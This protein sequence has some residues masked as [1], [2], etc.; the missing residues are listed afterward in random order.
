[1]IPRYTL[2]EMGAIWSERGALRGHAAGRARGRPRAGR[3]RPDP[4]RGAGRRSRRARASTS[5]GSPR[6]SGPRTTTSSRSS[7]RSPRSVG[8]GGPL[9]PPRADQQRRRRHRRSRS[10]S[11]PPASGCSST[12]DRLLAAIVAR[13]RAEADDRDDGPHPLGPRRADDVRAQARRLGVRARSRADAARG[14]G[15]RDRD[16][17]DLRARSGTYCH[18]GA[19]DRGRGAGGARAPRRSG[20]HPDRPARPPRGAAG[21]IA[22]LGG[23]LERFAT[24]VRNLQHTEIGELQ[25]PFKAGPEGLVRDAPQAQPDPV[26]ADRRAGAP[27]SRLRPH[28]ARGPAALARARHQPLAAPSG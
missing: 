18:L 26:R 1:M 21:A 3:A 25:E 13:A 19:G 11:G 20:Q 7:A 14:G 5:T 15:R 27:A 2:P 8:A 6:S 23:S 10:S 12:A 16:G 24:E 9:P 4:G 17:Q 28:R 22:I